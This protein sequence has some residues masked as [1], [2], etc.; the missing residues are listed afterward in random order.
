MRAHNCAHTKK[1]IHYQLRIEWR[2]IINRTVIVNSNKKSSW[3]SL[4]IISSFVILLQPYHIRPYG[5]CKRLIL[6]SPPKFLI[7]FLVPGSTSSP[8]VN[9]SEENVTLSVTDGRHFD[10][11]CN[12]N[13]CSGCSNYLSCQTTLSRHLPGVRLKF[14]VYVVEEHSQR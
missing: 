11:I 5:S 3:A 2:K 12:N 4:D 7:T 9:T 1:N 10:N 13:C 14:E 8:S 6:K